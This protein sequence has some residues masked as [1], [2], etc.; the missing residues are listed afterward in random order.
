MLWAPCTWFGCKVTWKRG[1][2]AHESE[3]DWQIGIVHLAL[4]L[5]CIRNGFGFGFGFSFGFS[6]GFGFALAL[7]L[8]LALIIGM[9]PCLGSARVAIAYL[10]NF[11]TTPGIHSDEK[12]KLVV[13][14]FGVHGTAESQGS[15]VS[16]IA[17]SVLDLPVPRTQLPVFDLTPQLP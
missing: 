13:V 6:F 3:L 5:V 10:C 1:N 4:P 16:R 8:A 2:L 17:F 12:G 14:V 11:P 7:A 15:D 9:G